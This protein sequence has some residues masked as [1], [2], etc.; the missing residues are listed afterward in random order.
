M[1]NLNDPIGKRTRDLPV[2]SAVPQLTVLLRANINIQSSIN[3]NY[4]RP[5]IFPNT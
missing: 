5:N 3:K 4:L 2:C 1:K